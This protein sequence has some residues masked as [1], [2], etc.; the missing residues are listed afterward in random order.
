VDLQRLKIDR[1]TAAPGSARR[2]R[3]G[4][5]RW[6]LLVL[7]LAVAALLLPRAREL[8][9]RWS[10]PEVLAFEVR[11]SSALAASAVSGT[12]ANGYV[13]A[14][15]RAALSAD[16]PGR[17]VEM[18]VQEGSVVAAGDVVARLYAEEYEATLRRA[19]AD[20]E[21]GRKAE[22]R[23]RAQVEEAR[24]T[25]GQLES[26]E[27]A[28]SAGALEAEAALRLARIEEKRAADLFEERIGTQEALDRAVAERERAEA[29]LEG[30]R[31]AVA[32]AA[33]ATAMGRATVGVTEAALAEASA[34][35]EVTRAERDLAQATLE[36]TYVR[37]P[38][39]GIVVLKDAEVGEVVSPN[40]Q[41]GN[42]RGSVVTMVDFDS[43]EVQVEVP[44][45]SIAAVEIDAP[46]NVYL[47]AYPSR[48]Y[49]GRVL[50][51][52]PTANRQKATIEVR[53]G[54]DERD[55]LLR[56]EMGARVVFSPEE[57]ASD[58]RE[59]GPR[60]LIPRAAVL[61]AEGSAAVFVLDG[62]VARRRAIRLGATSASRVVV[63]EGL[64]DGERIVSNPPASLEDGDRVRPKEER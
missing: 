56:P 62:D 34:R 22:D 16:T 14:R 33:S 55:D 59:S 41:G 21:A 29:R 51:V 63:E 54:F 7:G 47:D 43:L 3:R 61:E 10:S 30:A 18:N 58:A 44:E 42:S 45:T 52:W 36:K 37:A 48:L 4:G 38:F 11:E 6:V 9:Q 8:W 35:I 53:V 25:L 50:R 57:T 24:A 23:A 13:V 26:R 64:A 28:A 60:I 20:L 1:G 46:A 32:E 17:I 19:E 27:A 39:D 31:A 12:S 40:S 15:H 49:R 5:W 2:R